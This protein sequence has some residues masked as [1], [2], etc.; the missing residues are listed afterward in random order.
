MNRNPLILCIFK[1]LVRYATVFRQNNLQIHLFPNKERRRL[2]GF[3]MLSI[4]P[5]PVFRVNDVKRDCLVVVLRRTAGLYV[6]SINRYLDD[7][8]YSILWDR[9]PRD[10]IRR[11]R[12]QRRNRNVHL[13]DARPLHTALL[14]KIRLRFGYAQNVRISRKKGYFFMS[15]QKCIIS[16]VFC[17]PSAAFKPNSQGE[18]NGQKKKTLFQLRKSDLVTSR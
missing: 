2:H 5:I 15:R 18:W 12:R 13:L 1:L 3:R 14:L 4:S 11:R 17:F 7:R 6:K 16:I 10:R 8:T 9:P